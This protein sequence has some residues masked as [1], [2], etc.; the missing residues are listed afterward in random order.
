MQLMRRAIIGGL[1]V[2]TAVISGYWAFRL[3]YPPVIGGPQAWWPAFML[4]ASILLLGGGIQAVFPQ[5][6]RVWFV[7]FA[8]AFPLVL[9]AV[10]IGALP[11]RCWLIAFAVALCMGI[12]QAL[13]WALK[14]VEY[15]ALITSLI[16]AASW[17]PVSVNTLRAY[18]SPTAGSPNP[19]VLVFLLGMWVLIFESIFAGILLCKSP[20]S[21][22]R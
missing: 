2:L 4:G 11:S 10:V 5:V 17:V 6:R 16:V 7:L 13:A 12:T 8:G 9:C 3:M 21:G 22:E 18:F 20:R 1:C 19:Y 14:K 15:V